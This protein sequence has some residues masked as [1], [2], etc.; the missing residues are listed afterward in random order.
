MDKGREG[1]SYL[2]HGEG[3][4]GRQETERWKHGREWVRD[5]EKERNIP[6]ERRKQTGSDRGREPTEEAMETETDDRRRPG[7]GPYLGVLGRTAGWGHLQAAVCSLNR[8][9][10]GVILGYHGGSRACPLGCHR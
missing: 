5:G 3:R 9:V 10:E 6:S 4:E 7:G 1:G 2:I 8:E